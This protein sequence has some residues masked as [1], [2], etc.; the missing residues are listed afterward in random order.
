[1]KN[2]KAISMF[3]KAFTGEVWSQGMGMFGLADRVSMRDVSASDAGLERIIDD[4]E[5]RRRLEEIEKNDTID[6]KDKESILIFLEAWRKQ[7]K[8][9][10][11]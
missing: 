11:W 7:G 8:G 9:D 10:N 6:R 1:M 4:N 5:F 3:A 2:D